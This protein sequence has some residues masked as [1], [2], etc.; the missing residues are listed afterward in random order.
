MASRVQKKQDKVA[1][2]P[3]R[4]R[5]TKK[6]R[7][8]RVFS[9]GVKFHNTGCASLDVILGGGYAEGRMIN[10]I[11][12]KSSGKTLLAMEA[13]ANFHFAHPKGDKRYYEAESAWDADYI[14]SMGVPVDAITLIDDIETVEDWEDDF[15]GWLRD[16]VKEDVEHPALVCIDSWDAFSSK[17]EMEAKSASVGTYGGG[18]GKGASRAF[19]KACRLMTRARVTLIV[20]SQVRDNIGVT[21]GRKSKRAGGRALDFY[22]SQIIWLAEK[23]KIFKVI[24]GV[25]RAIG[26]DVIAKIDKNK[27]GLPFRQCEMPVFF[28]YGVD[29]VAASVIYL[30]EVK[31]DLP[32]DRTLK[33]WDKVGKGTVHTGYTDEEV[34]DMRDALTPMVFDAYEKTEVQFLPTRSKY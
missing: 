3:L 5:R 27:V 25:R 11:G 2:H 10:I 1:H 33:E 4:G 20:V 26:I 17:E 15:L 24:G 8:Q 31:A 34:S 30:R 6:F 18:K 9:A 22:A 7:A 32:K 21:F 14:E 19:R 23:G 12:D 16:R 29:D 28:G 13:F